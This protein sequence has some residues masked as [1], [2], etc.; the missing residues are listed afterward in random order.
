MIAALEINLGALRRNVERIRALVAP[1]RVWP[2]VKADAYGHGL[3]EVAS[4]LEGLAD[5]LCVYAPEEGLTL[6]EAGIKL[7]ILVTGPTPPALLEAAHAAELTLTLWDA[8]SYR[9]DLAAIARRRGSPFSVHVKIDTGVTRFGFDAPQAAEAIADLL[10]DRYIAVRG[11]FSHLAAVE[12]FALGF[13]LGQFASFDKALAPVDA[14]LRER[15]V[16][17][18]IAASAAAIVFPQ[19]RLDLVR[20]GIA[21]Y[22]LW[23]SPH[24]QGRAGGTLTLEPVL[25]WRSELAVVREVEA[26]RSVGYGCTFRTARPSRIGVV[27][28]G[29][30]EGVP[31]AVSNRGA[32]LVAGK[33][34]PIVGRVCMNVAFVDVTDV[35]QARTGSRATLIGVCGDETIAADDWALWAETINYEMISRL[36]PTIPRLYG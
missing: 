4:A 2:V 28:I 15:G 32:M 8:G 18:H 25:S 16:L 22:G 29:Y 17:R 3:I 12:E 23:P 11:V 9:R 7:P 34:A 24:T 14:L 27:P 13:S 30:A 19:A 10:A 31:R 5:G 26:G 33:R 20:P 1:S 35:P 36:P 21:I 6:R